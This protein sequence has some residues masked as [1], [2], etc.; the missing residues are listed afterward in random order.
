LVATAHDSAGNTVN[1]AAV[2]VNVANAATADTQAPVV[3]I[4]NPQDGSQVSGVVDIRV[5]V[6]DDSD[7]A[8]IRQTLYV[9]GKAV[10]SATGAVLSY[11]WNTRKA[12]SG[13]RTIQAVARD[14]A[15]N[16][17]TRSV[18]VRK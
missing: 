9:D 4:S 5:S 7:L 12:S 1:S 2:A 18:T 11:K 8:G 16:T 6:S 15:G 10:A 17:T 13:S 14:A 3:V